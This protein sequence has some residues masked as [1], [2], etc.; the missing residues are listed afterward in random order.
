MR[1]AASSRARGTPSSV[2]QMRTTASTFSSVTSNSG[3]AARARSRNSRTAGDSSA[4]STRTAGEGSG[5]ASG[6]TSKTRSPRS[7]S[8]ARLVT[9][10]VVFGSSVN[11]C[12]RRGAASRICSK[13]SSTSSIRRS[14]TARARS[15]TA[16]LDPESR[17]PRASAIA[18]ATRVGSVT[19][20]SS[21]ND[22]SSSPR[23]AIRWAISM[24]SRL[25]PIPPGPARVTR[26]T[27]SRSRSASTSATSACR[28]IVSVYGTGT[29]RA[30]GT[31]A[32]TVP[33]A[34]SKRSASSV[35]MSAATRSA[36]CSGVENET[37]ET[38]SS[39]LMRWIR[40]ASF[41]SRSAASFR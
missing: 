36:S 9:R 17:T 2:A 40:A 1:A 18:A 34:P 31:D 29:P 24:A 7:L 30:A 20:S 28:P 21:T 6:C 16:S 3:D 27:S 33:R 12:A 41:G 5:S 13:L 23:S 19:C 37:Y 14:P 26:R 4:V 15:A 10:K 22:T 32:A 35:A 11:S 38:V 25:L 8:S 39:A